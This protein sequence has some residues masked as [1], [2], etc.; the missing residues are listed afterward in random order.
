[1]LSTAFPSRGLLGDHAGDGAEP[2]QLRITGAQERT[3]T[4]VPLGQLLANSTLGQAFWHFWEAQLSECPVWSSDRPGQDGSIASLTCAVVSFEIAVISRQENVAKLARLINGC[5][6][7]RQ[8]PQE[9][10]MRVCLDNLVYRM[11]VMYFSSVAAEYDLNGSQ[12]LWSESRCRKRASLP[13]A[14]SKATEQQEQRYYYYAGPEV[15]KSNS[16][17]SWNSCFIDRLFNHR[18]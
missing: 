8:S 10:V 15:P 14:T 13:L 7:V 16:R 12:T 11:H 17:N 1:V 6:L 2:L 9:N 3:S 18:S 4:L 5:G